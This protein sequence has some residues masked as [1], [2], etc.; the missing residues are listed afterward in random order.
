MIKAF[1]PAAALEVVQ[2]LGRATFMHAAGIICSQRR[3]AL[4]A[5]AVPEPAR[6]P[7]LLL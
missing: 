7:D 4:L 1:G 5:C 2:L 3:G 6:D